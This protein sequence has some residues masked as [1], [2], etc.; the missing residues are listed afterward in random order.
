MQ[1]RRQYVRLQVPVLV[2]FANPTT[3]KT[4]RSYTLDISELGIRFPT[5]VRMPAGQQVALTLQLPFQDGTF[6]VTGE[7]AWI[8]EIARMGETQYEVGIRFKWMEETDLQRLSRFLK[9]FLSSSL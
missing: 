4:E 2:E 5:T 9:N 6:N 3:L 1:E 7:V 8:R